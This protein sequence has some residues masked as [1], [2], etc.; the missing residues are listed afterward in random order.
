M[1]TF[2]DVTA[3]ITAKSRT[4]LALHHLLAACR[5][6]ARIGELERENIGQPFG[7]FWEEILQNALGVATLTV[8]CA[9]CY[10]NEL[11]FEGSAI[12]P[13]LNRVAADLIAESL[14]RDP[15]LRRYSA[16]LA[17]RTGKTLEFGI[18]AV[19][20]IDVLIKLRNSVVHFRPEWFEEQAT[21]NKLSQILRGKFEPSPFLP[22]S[23]SIFPRAWASHS[24]AVWALQSTF[25][26]LDYFH[27]EATLPNPMAQ[28]SNQL[29]S[30]SAA[31]I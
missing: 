13:A 26:F 18:P 19:Q 16:V 17:I 4:N 20:G 14:D 15:I 28:F 1:T 10:A 22:A 24:F 6:A 12:S 30:L 8:A 23:E 11:F 31:A 29:S 21:H 27:S 9:E 25:K 2:A 5:F 7:G 3:V